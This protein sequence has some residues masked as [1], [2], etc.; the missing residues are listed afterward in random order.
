MSEQPVTVDQPPEES[1]SFMDKA[2]GIFYEPTSVFQ[3]V[4]K[5]G[6]K[7]ADWFVPVIVLA[8]LASVNVYVRFSTP[9]LRYQSIQIA[10]Q[11][12]DK[13][14]AQGKMTQEQAQQAKQRMESGSSSILEAIGIVGAVVFTFIAFFIVS[15]AWFLVGKFALKGQ[16]TYSHAMGVAGLATWIA[17]VGVILDIVLSVSMSRLDGGL[18]LGMLTSMNMSSK[19]YLLMSKVNLFT[20]WGL[21]ASAIGLA[22][23][24]GKKVFQSAVWVYGIWIVWTVGSVV[25]LSGR[26]G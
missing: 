14:V 12:I 10:E 7:F 9:D 1:M 20:L 2:A 6:V 19:G 8:I 21:F 17:A 23:L 15:A 5:S 25:L 24:S 16:I 18:Q 26:F 3:S 22:V 13:M 11:G 4:R